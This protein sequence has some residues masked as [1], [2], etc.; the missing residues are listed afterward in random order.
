MLEAA[1]STRIYYPLLVAVA[2]GLRRGELLGLR[3]ADVDVATGTLKIRQS[4]Q[5]A[6]GELVFK[7]PKSSKERVVKV[8]AT[9]CE[10]LRKHHA[11][12]AAAKLERGPKYLDEDLVFPAT[13]G[14]RWN[15]NAF[16]GQWDRFKR[17]HKFECRWHDLRHTQAT[18]LLTLGVHPKVVQE[19]L[20]HSTIAITMDLYS[21]VTPHLQ[22]EAA[23]KLDE[24]LQM[25]MPV[26]KEATT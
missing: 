15:P 7:A 19:R 22:D 25:I 24:T 14:S 11:E 20:G 5:R 6:G 9:L 23:G 12:Q 2:T 3:W 1:T 26:S 16:T 8:P 18:W 17:K 4:L 13:D 21:H 10:A